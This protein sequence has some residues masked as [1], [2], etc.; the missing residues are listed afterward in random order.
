MGNAVNLSLDAQAGGCWF[1]RW[2]DAAGASHSVQHAQVVLAQEGRV[3]R[4]NGAFG[5]GRNRRRGVIRTCTPS[6]Q[7]ER[8]YFHAVAR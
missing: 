7:P 8:A 3:L 2:R 5:P 4:L 1:E 6:E